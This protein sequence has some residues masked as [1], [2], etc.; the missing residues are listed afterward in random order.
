[1]TFEEL[2]AEAS[3]QGYSLV[4]KPTYVSLAKCSCGA[5]LSVKAYD[6]IYGHAYRCI[7]CGLES[8]P[9]KTRKNARL[10]WNMEVE[11]SLKNTE[12]PLTK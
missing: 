10:Y 2:K 1:M 6:T 3:R 4:K 7:K 9:S 5:K 8:V 11:K 12:K